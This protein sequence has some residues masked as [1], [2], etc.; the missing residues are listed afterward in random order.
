VG[1]TPRNAF[2]GPGLVDFDTSLAKNFRITERIG[3][4][5]RADLFNVM[6]HTNFALVTGN[7]IE[8]N[9]TFGQIGATAGLAGGNNGGPRVIQLTARITF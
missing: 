5:F 7:R 8:S 4:A 3:F 6:N 1:N 9:G 2:Y